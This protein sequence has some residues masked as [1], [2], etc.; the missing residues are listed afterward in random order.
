MKALCVD[1]FAREDVVDV[2]AVAMELAGEP[3]DGTTPLFEALFD[4]V[5]YMYHRKRCEANCPIPI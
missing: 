5:A 4:Y 2:G 1:A 3:R